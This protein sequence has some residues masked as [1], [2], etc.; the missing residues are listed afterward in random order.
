[1]KNRI[2]A[3]LLA[4]AM[5]F[6]FAACGEKQEQKKEEAPTVSVEAVKGVTIPEFKIKIC[7]VK[8]T[9]EDLAAY[10][11]YKYASNTVNSSG[12]NKSNVYIG[13]KMAD[14]LEACGI[15]GTFGKATVVA[16]DGYE[17]VYEGNL[18][19]DNCFIAISKDGALGKNGPWFAP[20]ESGTTGDYIQDLSKIEIEGA[21]VPE[22]K[23]GGDSKEEKKTDG[24]TELSPVDISDK[25]DKITFKDFS[26]KVNGKTVTNKDLEGLHIF[27]AKVTYAKSSGT[28]EKLHI[29]DMFLKMSLQSLE[30]MLRQ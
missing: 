10:D 18:L 21:V 26:F 14:V 8:I 27:K 25:T 28:I 2:L 4:L 22:G 20:C 16:T 12:T 5:V 23:A 30:L 29:A 19:A 13:F 3:L 24:P 1:M 9:N 11:L 15:T 17:V 6:C 7:G